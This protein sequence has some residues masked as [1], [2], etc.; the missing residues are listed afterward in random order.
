MSQTQQ[1]KID[2]A[3]QATAPIADVAGQPPLGPKK[4]PLMSIIAIIVVGAL[5]A[6][7]FSVLM[8]GGVASHPELSVTVIPTS[9]SIANGSQIALNFYATFKNSSDDAVGTNVST[10][11]ALRVDCKWSTGDTP[12][13]TLKRGIT[14]DGRVNYLLMSGKVGTSSLN[15]TLKYTDE[16]TQ[17]PYDVYKI[18]NVTVS[19]AVLSYVEIDPAEMPMYKGTSQIF[20]AKAVL[21]NGT[22]VTAAFTWW[23]SNKAVGT[24]TP[25]NGSSTTLTAGM[26]NASGDLV[27]NATYLGTTVSSTAKVK[28]FTVYP[29]ASTKSRIYNLLKAPLG[30]WWADGQNVSEYE[31]IRDTFPVAYSYPV[32]DGGSTIY[33]SCSLDVVAINISKANTLTNPWYVPV[34][35]P[36]VRGGNIEIDLYGTYITYAQAQNYSQKVKDNYDEWGWIWRTNGTVTMDRTAAKMVMNITDVEFNDFSTWKTDEFSGFTTKFSA[37]ISDQMNVVW[38]IQYAYEEGG[39]LISESYDVEKVGDKIVFKILDHLSWGLESLFGRW[40][41]ETFLQYEGFPDNCHFV[42]QISPLVSNFTLDATLQYFIVAMNSTRDGRTSWV[43]EFTHADS[44]F[45]TSGS[46]VS[47]LNPYFGKEYWSKYVADA[48]YNGW[49]DYDYT[50]TAWSLGAN[51]EITIVWPD[52]F[53]PVMGFNHSVAGNTSNIAPGKVSP[54]WIEPIPGEVPSNLFIDNAA[55]TITIKGPFDASD[56]SENTL[57]GR[58][59]RENWSRLGILPQGVPRI[60]FVVNNDANLKPVAMIS[61]PSMWGL[62][63]PLTLRSASYDVDSP[64]LTYDWFIDD[65]GPIGTHVLTQNAT[66]TWTVEANYTVILNVTDDG[67]NTSSDMIVIDVRLNLPPTAV[68]NASNIYGDVQTPTYFNGAESYDLDGTIA[69]YE[70]DFGDGNTSVTNATTPSTSH[71]YE[72]MGIYD[73]TLT[74]VDNLG[75]LDIDTVKFAITTDLCAKI[76]MQRSA[77]VGDSIVIKG[78]RSFTFSASQGRA[79]ANWTWDFGDGSSAYTQNVTHAWSSAGVFTVNLFVKDSIGLQSLNATAKIVIAD[80]TISGLGLSLAKHSLLPGDSTTLTIKAVNDAGKVDNTF[81]GNVDLKAWNLVIA[82]NGS[83]LPPTLASGWTLPTPVNFVVGDQGV[84]TVTVSC[85]T[86][87]SYNISAAVQGSPSQNGS[88]F[89]TVNNRTVEIKIYGIFE[90]GL[91]DYWAKRGEIYS[92]VDEGFRNYTPS[93]LIS[94]YDAAQ[95]SVASLTTAYV[96]NVEARNIPEINM[97]SPT[98]TSLR[99]PT[100]GGGNA[101]VALDFHTLTEAQM[102]AL[103]GVYID[104]GASSSWEGYEQFLTCNITMDREAAEQIMGLPLPTTPVTLSDGITTIYLDDP[105]DMAYW[106][107]ADSGQDLDGDGIGD[108]WPGNITTSDYWNFGSLTFGNSY[109][110]GEGGSA[111][112]GTLGRLDIGSCEEYWYIDQLTYNSGM[113]LVYLDADHV[114]LSYWTVG[115][116]YD[117]L[118]SK[119][120]YWGGNGSGS[121]NYP[122]GTPNGIVPYEPWYSNMSL[123]VDIH[124][125]CANLTMYAAMD[126]GFTAGTSDV[127]PAGTATFIWEVNRLDYWV[128]DP[129]GGLSELDIYRPNLVGGGDPSLDP[130]YILT[131]PGSSNFGGSNYY[132]YVPAVVTLKP[133]ESIFMQAPRTMA[134]G[135]LPQKMIGDYTDGSSYLGGYYDFLRVLEVFGNATIHPV[136]CYPDTYTID[137]EMGDLTIVGPFVPKITYRSDITWLVSD[138]APNIELWIQ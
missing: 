50:P 71:Q 42:A 61:A 126:Y 105:I 20:K 94:R 5:I 46:Y 26:V 112:M 16:K 24:I 36:S 37:W 65:G 83:A 84:K 102:L 31:I 35:N 88:V 99:H 8:T 138:P 92:L 44:V 53:S 10:S 7:A 66:H 109:L 1:E 131:D 41:R 13:G 59:L 133:G 134:V 104:P 72:R 137:K 89:A 110:G 11:I 68:L 119:L 123:R 81:A 4:S 34:L 70:W 111:M 120:L 30:Q 74:V 19:I 25:S 87:G 128:S 56:W 82:A 43:L 55:K 113:K 58:E 130:T 62:N 45:S 27:C 21:T 9:I 95:R 106:W 78:N 28:V 121:P 98:F 107:D 86:P 96:M 69:S 2:D 6:T 51:D 63:T 14:I 108:W 17:V 127:A 77:T 115:Y 132:D 48:T 117:A 40:W 22:E 38:D 118:L 116:G 67:P 91:P 114:N 97:S 3:A 33:S 57:A 103:E 12:L 52:A 75:G 80:P 54:L 73:V 122:N 125:N 32:P 15:L 29:P 136:G 79:L 47:E 93:I 100:T 18:V 129:S 39:V 23:L 90:Q 135:Y 76:A 124:K 85:A 60:E 101:T 64:S 49:A